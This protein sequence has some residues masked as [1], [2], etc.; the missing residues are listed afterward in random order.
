MK[1]KTKFELYK[2]SEIAGAGAL[3][4]QTGAPL[5]TREK[6]IPANKVRCE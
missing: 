5:L 4:P 1:E 2:D 3:L 6:A